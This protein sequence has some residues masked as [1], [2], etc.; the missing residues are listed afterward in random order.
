MGVDRAAGGIPGTGG[1]AAGERAVDLAAAVG[2][3]RRSAVEVVAVALERAARLDEVLHAFVSIDPDR[4]LAEAQAV[5]DRCRRG[6]PLPLAGVPVPLKA[7][8]SPDGPLATRLRAA[9]AV[10]IG[11]TSVPPRGYHQTWGCTPAGR[12]RN[13]WDLARS[14]G[15][16]SAGAA[17]AVAAGIVPLATGGDSAGSL[18]I[19][20]AFCGLVG[21]KPTTGLLARR[22]PGRFR[23]TTSGALT[24]AVVDQARFLDALAGGPP[25]ALEVALDQA[26]GRPLRAAWSDDL[27]HVPV[28]PS[29]AA[30]ARS[31]ADDLAAD[32]AISWVDLPVTLP[33]LRH[34]WGRLRRAER[35]ALRGEPVPDDLVTADDLAVRAATRS[36]LDRLLGVVDVLLLPTTPVGAQPVDEDPP[37]YECEL[38]WA[39]N[40]AGLPAT[41]VPAGTTADGR[42]AGLQLVARRGHDAA[43]LWL[44]RQ[45]E[46]RHG[47]AAA[48][49]LAATHDAP[50]PP[51]PAVPDGPGDLT[52]AGR[53]G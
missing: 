15:G 5:D 20:A 30:R 21:H 40:V 42:H 24:R 26:A 44:A 2:S 48:A 38:T 8:Q 6:E 10:V 34:V 17:A 47:V 52:G 33:S 7:T 46:R 50:R 16:S 28:D 53:A 19:P 35:M 31:R 12:T 29:L 3:G 11:S 32:G 4:A 13:P 45:L 1:P 23:L 27:G 14:P 39:F 37:G 51:R 9:G 43:C 25:G 41:S 18:R 36:E 22:R 49:P